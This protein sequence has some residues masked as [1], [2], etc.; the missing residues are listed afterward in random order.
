MSADLDVLAPVRDLH[1]ELPA[2]VTLP[3]CALVRRCPQPAAEVDLDAVIRAGVAALA[4]RLHGLDGKRVAV[5]SG[6]RGIRGIAAIVAA[7]VRALQAQGAEAFVVPAMGSHGS[8]EAAG[9]AQV[10][11][12]LGITEAAVGAPIVATM[13]T[14]QAGVTSS[15]V[16]VHL[17]AAV[18]ASDG[19]V[20]VNRVKPHTD[21][22]GDF[23]SGLAKM[24]AI[25][26]GNIAGATVVHADGSAQLPRVITEVADVLRT[27]GVLLGG[28]AVLEDSLGRTAEV[29][30]VQAD[31]IA[32]EHERRLMLRARTLH[33]HLPFENLD[34]LVV[35]AMGKNISGAGMDTN[36]LG[37]FWVPGVEEPTG[38]H[39]AVVTAHRLT[40]ESHGNASGIGLAD[41]VPRR[42]VA[43]VDL[44]A[45]YVNAL[46]SSTGGLRRSR[47]PMVLPTDR[48]VVHAAARMC[49]RREVADL[50]LVRVASTLQLGEMLVTEPLLPEVAGDSSLEVVG[51]PLP[52]EFGPDG[53]LPAWPAR[54]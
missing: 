37:R 1:V 19:V 27:G 6:S 53:E 49:G 4:E 7:T 13:E 21:F 16:P 52:W 30:F 28:V 51:S 43:D 23:G 44:R 25:G 32:G 35:D 9:Q 40:A 46:T 26:L 18:A 14:V 33:G 48:D 5:A 15:G 11:A 12:D 2:G 20:V 24:S 54:G 47:L 10:L 17:D 29:H 38:P 22:A 41:L 3:R 50:R 8:S 39:I 34:V 45:S 36:V 31:G 42:L